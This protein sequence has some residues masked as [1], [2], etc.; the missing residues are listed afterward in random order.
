M[1]SE[2][3][4]GAGNN[5]Y[6]NMDSIHALPHTG[7]DSDYGEKELNPPPLTFLWHVCTS[8]GPKTPPPHHRLLCAGHRPEKAAAGKIGG[9]GGCI[10]G[11]P[12]ICSDT[13]DSGIIKIPRAPPHIDRQ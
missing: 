3:L 6:Q 4:R 11:V 13:G 5:A 7:H 1:S 10:T 12:G 2:G 9:K 8:G